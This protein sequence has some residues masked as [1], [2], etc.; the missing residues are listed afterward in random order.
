M[1]DAEMSQLSAATGSLRSLFLTMM[2][3]HHQ[4]AVAMAQTEQQDGKF[5][6]AK[7]L[8]GTIISAQQAEIVEM[9]QLLGG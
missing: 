9:Q 3:K 8:A 6:E 4:G 2:V 1:S 5:A 7:Q